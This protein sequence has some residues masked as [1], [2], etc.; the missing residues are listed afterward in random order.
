MSKTTKKERDTKGKVWD[1]PTC[2]ASMPSPK[3]VK[4]ITLPGY[5]W[6]TH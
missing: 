1:S 5:Q 4:C 3:G 2:R 6:V